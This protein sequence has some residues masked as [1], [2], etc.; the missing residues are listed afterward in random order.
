[1]IRKI[2]IAVVAVGGYFIAAA[3]LFTSPEPQGQR[4]ETPARDAIP[5]AQKSSSQ[6]SPIDGVLPEALPSMKAK[7]AEFMHSASGGRVDVES[8]HL[9]HQIM[10][11]NPNEINNLLDQA[12]KGTSDLATQVLF[13]RELAMY[14]ES[15]SKLLDF[16][17][18]ES[19]SAS[20]IHRVAAAQVVS[21]LATDPRNANAHATLTSLMKNEKD[22]EA[23]RE[24]LGNLGGANFAPN[25]RKAFTEMLRQKSFDIAEPITRAQTT[26]IIARFDPSTEN[27]RSV[28]S[29]LANAKSPEANSFLLGSLRTD[30]PN[31]ETPGMEEALLK[32]L[33]SSSSPT[34]DKK[35][36]AYILMKTTRSGEVFSMATNVLGSQKNER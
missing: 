28:V 8:V 18:V 23:F 2:F 36:A 5:Q 34:E 10:R 6:L 14:P 7:L 13:L 16:A 30:R 22:P 19:Q 3:L 9:L 27:L 11:A 32:I 4:S 33:H 26:A 25:D 29:E 12:L 20:P 24:M 35:Q 15:S 1:M 31:A 17:R 21:I